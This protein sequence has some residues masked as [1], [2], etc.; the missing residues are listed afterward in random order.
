M[1]IHIDALIKTLGDFFLR[2][3]LIK[4]SRRNCFDNFTIFFEYF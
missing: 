2:L 4:M 1:T 3:T